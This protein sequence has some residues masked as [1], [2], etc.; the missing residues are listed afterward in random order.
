MGNIDERYGFINNY[1]IGDEITSQDGFFWDPLGVTDGVNNSL[2]PFD[3]QGNIRVLR[4][5]WKS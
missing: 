1:M 5:Y 4:V 3:T 2:L